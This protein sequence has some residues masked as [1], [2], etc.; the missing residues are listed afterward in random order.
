VFGFTP[1]VA[2]SEQYH[3][4]VDKN[5]IFHSLKVLIKC[6]VTSN[7]EDPKEPKKYLKMDKICRFEA[8]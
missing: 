8:K 5:N 2:K 7:V 4:Y 1:H 6:W 3:F